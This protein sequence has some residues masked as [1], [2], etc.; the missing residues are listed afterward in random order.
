MKQVYF[1]SLK[2]DFIE[3]VLSLTCSAYVAIQKGKKVLVVDDDLFD[4]E[5]LSQSLKK[6]NVDIVE[7]KKM[8]FKRVAIFYGKGEQI[9]DFTDLFP[10]FLPIETKLNSIQGD[11]YPEKVKELFFCYEING[12]EY[13]ETYPE[14]RSE[15]IVI[16]P[17]RATYVRE[18]F[19]LNKA[20]LE[21][22]NDIMKH[23]RLKKVLVENVLPTVEGTTHLIHVLSTDDLK[24][25][26]SQIRKDDSVFIEL[27]TKKYI[28]II[29]TFITNT[30][31]TILLLQTDDNVSLLEFLEQKGNPY[32][33]LLTTDMD[34]YTKMCS[35][36][37]LFVGVFNMDKLMG[38]ACSYYLHMTVPYTKSALINIDHL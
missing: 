37:G 3:K 22:Y 15:D 5:Y 13:T 18:F 38:S 27:A 23:V 10:P 29:E 33:K 2:G 20:T 28:E 19:W 14:E 25:C 26:A 11:P 36:N 30:T 17:S 7:K 9:I 35:A 6:Y 8:N 1:S 24:K 32:Q 4:L 31:D 12:I 16:D 21:V 34:S